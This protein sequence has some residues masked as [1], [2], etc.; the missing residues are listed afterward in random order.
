VYYRLLYFLKKQ[1]N[2]SQ[3]TAI[4]LQKP[5]FWHAPA[6]KHKT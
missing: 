2:V 3:K 1:G 6:E 5:Q 4:Q